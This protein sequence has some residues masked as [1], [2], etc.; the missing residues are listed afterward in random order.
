MT[1]YNRSRSSSLTP[2]KTTPTRFSFPSFPPIYPLLKQ[3]P[4]MAKT[5]EGIFHPRSLKM[6]HD[7]FKIHGVGGGGGGT[8]NAGTIN[9]KGA[10]GAGGG[11]SEPLQLRGSATATV[12]GKTREEIQ[13]I[14]VDVLRN[15]SHSQRTTHVFVGAC[16]KRASRLLRCYRD[17]S[18][19]G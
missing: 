11:G 14:F 1:F 4:I 18:C 12:R 6:R 16:S 7:M 2:Q 9:S 8:T 3:A 15:V 19:G 17:L 13:K 5:I 10:G